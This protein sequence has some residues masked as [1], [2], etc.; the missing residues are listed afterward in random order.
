MKLVYC[1]CGATRG[2]LTNSCRSGPESPRLLDAGSGARLNFEAD[3]TDLA[4]PG[5]G[6]GHAFGSLPSQSGGALMNGAPWSEP[7]GVRLAERT[8]GEV[9][10]PGDG[11]RDLHIQSRAEPTLA[12]DQ[13]GRAVDTNE[14]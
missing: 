11:G 10:A 6:R 9:P 3:S 1:L 8:P 14:P 5:R 13:R 2:T 4:M 7:L 12:L